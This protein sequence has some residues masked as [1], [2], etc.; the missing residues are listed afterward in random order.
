MPATVFEAERK[1]II[2]RYRYLIRAVRPLSEADRKQLRKALNLAIDA[3][4]NTRRK[5]GDPYIYHPLEVARIAAEEIGLGITSVICALLHDV[6]EDSDYK[7][8]YIETHFGKKVAVIIDGLTKIEEMPEAHNPS[9]QAENFRKVIFT[10]SEDVRVILLKL[11]DRLHNMRTIDALPPNKQMKFAAETLYLYAPLALRLGLYAIKS[12]L[13]DHSMHITEPEVYNT[14]SRKLNQNKAD[15]EKFT[16]DFIKPIIESLNKQKIVY[17]IQAREKSIHSIWT[18][19]NEKGVSFDGIYDLFAIRI[20]IESEPPNE[21]IDCWRVY[22]IVTDHYRPQPDRLRDWIATPKANGYESLHTTVMSRTGQWVEIQIRSRRMDEIAEKGYAAHW[23]YKDKNN[24]NGGDLTALDK[25]LIRI[26][27]LLKT[28]ESDSIL[29]LDDFKLNLFIDEIFVYTPKG[30]ERTLPKKST[31]LDFAYAIHTDIGNTCIAAKV[32]HRLVPLHHEL[33]NGDQ[34]EIITSKKQNPRDEW[35]KWVVT[36]RA[37][38][39]IKE[40][41]R[42][43]KKEFVPE[44][45]NKLQEYFKNLGVEMSRNNLARLSEFCKY[46]SPIDM[47]YAVAKG[48]ITQRDIKSCFAEVSRSSLLDSILKPFSRSRT[49]DHKNL[50]TMIRE[51]VKSSPEA[52]LLGDDISTVNYNLSTCCNP[53]PGDDV[54]GFLEPDRLITIHRTSCIEAIQLSSRFGDRIVKTKWKPSEN[55]SFLTG[56]KISGI[57]RQGLLLEIFKLT[58]EKHKANVKSFLLDSSGEFWQASLMIYVHGTDELNHIIRDLGKISDIKRV[59]RIDRMAE[60][61]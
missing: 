15:R 52:L 34:I 50:A 22:A 23:K 29:F 2:K 10:L 44:G 6:V 31:A 30:D 8:D 43:Q 21:K 46:L 56:I 7:L 59:I 24:G 60:K 48:E 38:L 12:E 27:D 49:H 47:Y 14:L 40:A 33:K 54:I 55:I 61:S 3:H 42:E 16:S 9:K 37:K 20:I 28:S 13:E 53:I 19:M 11:A 41:L 1:E 18:K 5:N 4:K 32:N 58:S 57:D 26:R 39:Q 25:Y 45:K 36:A 51:K 35:L 17:E